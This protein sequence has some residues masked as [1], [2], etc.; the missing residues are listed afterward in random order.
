MV[1]LSFLT[2]SSLLLLCLSSASATV[3]DDRKAYIVYMGAL[4]SDSQYS[5]T[6]HH[7]HILQQVTS[8]VENS[9]VRNYGRSFN[10]FEAKLTESEREKLSAMEGVVSIFP[11]KKLDLHTTRSWDFMGFGDEFKHNPEAESDIVVGVIDGGI[12]PESKSFSDKGLSP[13]PAKWKG[14]CKGGSNFT[15]NNKLIGARFY[16]SESARDFKGHGTHTSSIAV[17]SKVEGTSFYGIANGTARGGVPSARIAM[18]KVCTGPMCDTGAILAAFDDAIAD[19]VD[20]ITI[21]MGGSPAPLESDPISIA[22]FHA[23]EKG[24]LTV[25][26]AGNT[27]QRQESTGSTSPWVL[28]VAASTTDRKFVTKV[29]LGNGKELSGTS[30]N[31]F[32]LNGTNF[33]FSYGK[34]GSRSCSEE[35]ARR[36]K[37][38]CIDLSLVGKILV[39]DESLLGTDLI[40]S[41][42]IGAIIQGKVSHPVINRR[43]PVAFVLQDQYSLL[44]SYINSTTKPEGT[45]LKTETTNGADAPVIA[46]FSSRG[47]NTIL[48]DILKPDIMAPGVNILAAYSPFAPLVSTD[49]DGR[50]SSY[51]FLSGTSMSCPHVAG[52]AAYLKTVY[53][54]WSPSAIQSAIM[55]TAWPMNAS[56]SE[57]ANEF[58]YGSGHLNPTKAADPGL[59]YE[60]TGD[61][62]LKMLCSANYTAIQLKVIA[63]RAVSCP[64]GLN[65]M[66]KDLNYP[67]M[68]ARFN[69]SSK[70]SEI[71]F[72][73][74]VTNVG[75]ASSTYKAKVVSA[76]S[77]L[78]VEIEPN[79]LSFKSVGEKKPFTVKVSGI[80]SADFQSATLV[81]SDGS[82]TVRSPIVISS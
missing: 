10:G 47:P 21:S 5:A 29:A 40:S 68:S 38:G 62:Y 43:I 74:T 31:S 79:T 54:K 19:G 44:L 18:Y 34:S 36:C 53:P 76:A 65:L 27:G 24:I 17:G 56:I 35:D 25:N 6:S 66:I 49:D 39:C 32:K 33:P 30:I 81:W 48:G 42:A 20:V 9:L 67:S 55:T 52:V 45:I 69:S 75:P 72:S 7:Q 12:W 59:V 8:S 22:A 57:D 64:K 78:K 58:A 50:R 80:S 41:K 2:L 3:E 63:G 70:P 46:P 23:M 51:N 15:C 73:R 14:V 82:R 26:S 37:P 28:T 4:P 1:S 16:V 11:S 71:T 61:D 77:D 13:P 60:T